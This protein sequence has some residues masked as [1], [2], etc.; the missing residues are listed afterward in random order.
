MKK[1]FNL[2][3]KV[4]LPFL[5]VLAVTYG[6]GSYIWLPQALSEASAYLPTGF[7]AAQLEAFLTDQIGSYA[8]FICISLILLAAALM[9]IMYQYVLLPTKNLKDVAQKMANGIYDV[10]LPKAHADEMGELIQ[11]FAGMQFLVVNSQKS[12]LQARDEAQAS[13]NAKTSFLANMSHELRTPMNGIIGLSGLLM[14]SSLDVEQKEFTNA[15]NKSA[16]NLLSLLNDILDFSKIEAGELTLES[17]DFNLGKSTLETVELLRPLADRKSIQIHHNFSPTMPKFVKGDPARLQQI[18]NNL[19][20][21]ALKF[22]EKGTISID[23]SYRTEGD[24]PAVYFRVEDTGIGISADKLDFIF[25]KFT[26]AETSTNRKFGGTGLGLA[27][28][29]ELVEMMDGQIGVE[30]IEGQG[31][32]FWFSIPFDVV[33]KH[34]EKETTESTADEILHFPTARVLV[35]DDHPINLMFAKKLL[36]RMGV[37]QI[38]EAFNG[39]DAIEKF[40]ENEYDLILMDCQMPELDGFEVTEKI[41][42]R[43]QGSGS[44]VPIIAVTADAMRGAQEKCLAV[45]MDDYLSKPIDPVG[46]QQSMARFIKPSDAATEVPPAPVEGTDETPQLVAEELSGPPPVNLEH[47]RMFTEGDR[48]E[49]LEIFDLFLGQADESI[50][51][52]K[53]NLSDGENEAWKKAAHKLKGASANLGAEALSVHCKTAEFGFDGS[54]AAKQ[55]V[56]DA[57]MAELERAASFLKKVHP[58]EV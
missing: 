13:A 3:V 26:Q 12:L 47:L 21:N 57:I 40:N 42:E 2:K 33:E 19:V 32:T 20:G 14:D 9:G 25:N 48:E 38:D 30:S 6:Y 29:K 50:Q 52:L 55:E 44:H 54:A 23:V 24:K 51:E 56:L 28:T 10:A 41:R 4:L 15:V 39:A 27:I 58:E 16:K 46:L 8:V 31:S 37:T 7:E 35:A 36:K 43:E 45:G 1:I 18:L 53:D 5:V 17:I 11:R 49:E 34:E 22:T